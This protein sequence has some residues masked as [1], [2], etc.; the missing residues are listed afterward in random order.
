MVT[1]ATPI[2]HYCK[3]F[4]R[5]YPGLTCKAFPKGIPDEVLSGENDHSKKINGQKGDYVFEKEDP[6]KIW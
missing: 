3:H 2:C 4:N 5:G 1:Y 6:D